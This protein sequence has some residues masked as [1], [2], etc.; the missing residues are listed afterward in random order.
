MII[1]WAHPLK[2]IYTF[3]PRW[4][5][6]LHWT[7][8]RGSFVEAA[9]PSCGWREAKEVI[10]RRGSKW[11]ISG[12]LTKEAVRLV[13]RLGDP[14]FLPI[15]CVCTWTCKTILPSWSGYGRFRKPLRLKIW[16]NNPRSVLVMFWSGSFPFHKENCNTERRIANLYRTGKRRLMK[17][18]M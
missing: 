9:Y 12:S 8:F 6:V 3:F 13:D 2:T 7:P 16:P 18:C 11:V 1:I 4:R 15:A 17:P 14:F 10:V 5:A